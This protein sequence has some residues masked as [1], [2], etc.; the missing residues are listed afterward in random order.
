MV[1]ISDN[2]ARSASAGSRSAH[3]GR[4][5]LSSAPD[6]TPM[7]PT[8]ASPPSPPSPPGPPGRPRDGAHGA[9]QPSPTMS[10][11]LVLIREARHGDEQAFVRL[12]KKNRGWLRTAAALLIGEHLARVDVEDLLQ[13]TFFYAFQRIQAGKFELGPSEGAFRHYLSRILRN[14]V[15]DAARRRKAKKRDEARE[16]AMADLYSSTITTLGFE[17]D[18]PTPSQHMMGAEL[19]SGVRSAI[20]GLSEQDRR[21]LHY[22]LVCH[23]SYEEMLPKLTMVRDGKPLLDEDGEPVPVTKVGTA[24]SMFSRARQKLLGMLRER[25]LVERGERTEGAEGAEG[26]AQG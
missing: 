13:E 17:A 12:Y 5:G 20:A 1:A 18:S 23:M 4:G 2:G 14:K 25:G 24:K 9:A 3:T 10:Q 6:E 15:R 11:T 19:A 16:K 7:V 8:M 26:Q 21:I 22:R